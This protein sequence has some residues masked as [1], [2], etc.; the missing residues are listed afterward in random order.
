MKA[1]KISLKAV[2]KSRKKT[3]KA[4]V[5]PVMKGTKGNGYK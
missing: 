3:G 4:N 1:K 2:S 5:D